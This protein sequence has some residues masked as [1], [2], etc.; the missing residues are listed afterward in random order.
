MKK[1]LT[2]GLII[3]LPIVLTIVVVVWLFDLMTEPFMGIIEKLIVAY[4]KSE[5]ID[6]SNHDVLVAVI[7]RMV[8]LIVLFLLIWA[9]GFI[10]RKFFFHHF[11]AFSK[12]IFTKIPFIKTVYTLTYEVTHALLKE[13]EK[14]FKQ[15]VLIPFPF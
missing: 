12:R 4:E 2:A 13:G 11:I 3:L 8:I 5:G 15:T 9:L 1:D 10:A 14:T 6:I 7:S